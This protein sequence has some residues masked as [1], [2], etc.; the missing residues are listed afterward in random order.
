[1]RA[2]LPIYMP[3]YL[4]LAEE[5]FQ[6]PSTYTFYKLLTT[7]PFTLAIYL[8]TLPMGEKPCLSRKA[9]LP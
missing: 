5:G 3:I 2:F 4:Y 1:V 9:L 6:L 8:R 7:L